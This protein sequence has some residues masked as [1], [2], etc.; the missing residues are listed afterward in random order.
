MCIY[1]LCILDYVRAWT[2]AAGHTHVIQIRAFNGTHTRPYGVLDKQTLK[3]TLFFTPDW[4][5]S[6]KMTATTDLHTRRQN[7]FPAFQSDFYKQIKQ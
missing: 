1:I 2:C 6:M 4:R 3:V 7:C 5:F